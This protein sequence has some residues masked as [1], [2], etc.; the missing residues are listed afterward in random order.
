M[1]R[2]A[3]LFLLVSFLITA[4]VG[5]G[6]GAIIFGDN[7]QNDKRIYELYIPRDATYADV[8]QIL[9]DQ[10]IIKNE[11]SFDWVATRMNY[12]NTVKGG[13]YFIP[14]TYSNRHLLKDLRNG[15][16]SVP[17]KMPINSIDTKTELYE[18][19]SEFIEA[20][21]ASLD[22]IYNNADFLKKHDLTVDNAWATVMADTYEFNWNTDSKAFFKRMQSEFKKFWN[23][24][25]VAKAKAKGMSPMDCIILGSIIEKESTKRDEYRTIAGVYINRLQKGWPL[26]ADPTVKFALQDPSIKRILNKHLEI[27]S[28]YNTYKNQGLP[29]GPIGLPEKTTIDAVLN[30]QDHSYM[31]FCANSDFSGY[32][33]FAKTLREHNKNAKKYQKAL[34]QSNIF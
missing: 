14:N 19:V 30:A 12:P 17:V 34:N 21:A 26:Q 6:L 7:I 2:K 9:I 3:L 28:P 16:A 32:H 22:S 8:K 15:Y 5:T 20:D 13:K 29:P 11:R 23:A 24:D 33:I 1:N 25:R 31:Y 18:K 4:L 10:E 27:D